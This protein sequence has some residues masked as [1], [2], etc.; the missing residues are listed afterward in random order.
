MRAGAASFEQF[1]FSQRGSRGEIAPNRSGCTDYE[2]NVTSCDDFT[3]HN[4]DANDNGAV[5]RHARPHHP[6]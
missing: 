6:V 5:S 3:L 1:G 4:T 2:R